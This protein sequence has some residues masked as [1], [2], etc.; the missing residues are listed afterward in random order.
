MV[1]TTQKLLLLIFMAS[2]LI[3]T[4][5]AIRYSEHPSLHWDAAH[6]ALLARNLAE[7]NGFSNE[8]GHPTA[9]RTPLYP[10]VVSVIFRTVGERYR[11]VNLLQALMMALTVTASAWFAFRLAGKSAMLITAGLTALNPSALRMT[12]MLLT[13]TTFAFLLVLSLIL[14][15]WALRRPRKSAAAYQAGF[16]AAGLSIG[17]ATLCRP[18]GAIWAV[19]AA[20]GILFVKGKP[21][22]VRIASAAVLLAAFAVPVAPWMAR[23]HAHFGAASIATTGGRTFW[24]FRHRDLQATSERGIP[25]EEF[26]RVNE[27]VD[28]RDIAEKGGD[29]S[30]MAPV[31][32]LCPRYHA[33]FHDQDTIDRFVGLSE[34]EADR[35]FYSM[36]IEYTLMHPF[37]VFMESLEDVLRIF[38]PLDRSGSVNPVL[39]IALPLVLLGVHGIWKR[40]SMSGLA[41]LTALLPLAASSFLILYEPRYRIPY[42]PMLLIAAGV[43][44]AGLIRTD[45]LMER[46]TRILL[47]GGYLLFCAASYLT[48]SGPVTS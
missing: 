28:Q 42:E 47:G 14:L 48:L 20:G 4:F 32:N 15:D 3:S 39:F 44:L 21:V 38:S 25:P 43:G 45:A 12:G 2:L 13:E 17:I 37:R 22:F 23:N 18:N 6:Y 24:E 29:V 27:I 5:S 35:E 26:L 31:F 9:Y 10:A 33:Y 34:G 11:A 41:L 46:K 40:N 8:P 1:K 7:G 16:A 36:G 19:I 30:R